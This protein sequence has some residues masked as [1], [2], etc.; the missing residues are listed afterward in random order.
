MARLTEMGGGVIFFSGSV[1]CIVHTFYGVLFVLRKSVAVYQARLME[2][3]IVTLSTEP[4]LERVIPDGDI[5]NPR[6]MAPQR[7]S[8]HSAVNASQRL[9]KVPSAVP[10]LAVVSSTDE[11]LSVAP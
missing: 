3:N 11:R 9:S 2:R 10:R 1:K 6:I 5:C 7:S 4:G 8:K